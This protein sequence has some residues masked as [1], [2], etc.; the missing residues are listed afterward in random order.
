VD[1][2]TSTYLTTKELA[3]LLRIKERKVYDLAATGNIPCTRA[4]GK[5][6]FPRDAIHTWL[7]AHQRGPK[8]A[9][10][11][12][13]PSVFLGSHDPL[14]EWALRESQCGIPTY[15]DSSKDGVE[16]FAAFQGLACGLHVRCADGG[17]NSQLVEA[18][19]AGMP[20]VLIE[21]AKRQRGLIFS[22]TLRSPLSS[23]NQIVD[24]RVTP[25]QPG[26]GAQSLLLELIRENGINPD[27]LNWSDPVRTEIDAVL[28]VLEGK[29][30]VAFGL[31]SLAQQYRLDF[32]P[33][34]EERFD[35]LMMRH[36]YFE[37]AIQSLMA[38]CTTD[39]FKARAGE[40]AGCNTDALG[41]VHYNSSHS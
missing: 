19:C 33:V 30:D 4:T 29:S 20:V 3:A 26:A 23:I 25:R 37:P 11:V 10:S 34:I 6:L 40:L 28:S 32:L 13:V 38:F 7:A 41:A 12:S 16:R 2:S 14:L 31:Q 9:Q 24:H 22:P 36:T 1:E 15:F 35:L 39:R 18:S 17:W 27:Q 5:L 8:T 21:W